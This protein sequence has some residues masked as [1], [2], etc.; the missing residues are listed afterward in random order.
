ML[1][2]AEDDN[3]VVRLGRVVFEEIF[4]EDLAVRQPL[5]G[6][7]VLVQPVRVLGNGQGRA[8]DAARTGVAGNCAPA[9]ANV[10]QAVTRLQ[11]QGLGHSGKFVLGGLFQRLVIVVE[12][13]VRVEMVLA[14]DEGQVEIVAEVIVVRDG[15]AVEADAVAPEELEIGPQ[16]EAGADIAL[17][18]LTQIYEGEH[19]ALD[20]DLA[21]DVSAPDGV[22]V[23]S[24]C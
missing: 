19:I 23:E 7:E 21:L 4:K 20:F 22:F 5:F 18:V 24:V 3:G 9:R 16:Q 2:D 17:G 15:S 12:E 8:V 11:V 10:E 1:N 6:D 13:A 14:I